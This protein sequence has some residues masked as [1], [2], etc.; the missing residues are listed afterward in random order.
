MGSSGGLTA[1][2]QPTQA[3]AKQYG[4]TK[5]ISMAGPSVTDMQKTAELEKVQFCF[6]KCLRFSQILT[7]YVDV[8]WNFFSWVR[9]FLVR[10]GLYES[11]EEAA[12]REDVLH[13]L[14]QVIVHFFF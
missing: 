10:S 11:K 3:A 13:R 9:K 2:S 12:K 7:L 4:V 6:L 8:L 1:S 14:G 5:P